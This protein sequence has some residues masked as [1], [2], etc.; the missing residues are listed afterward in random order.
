MGHLS[1]AALVR[2]KDLKS[3]GP[4]QCWTGPH[5][6]AALC[7]PPDRG[8]GAQAGQRHLR[9]GQRQHSAQHKES[10]AL[11]SWMVHEY[12]PGNEHTPASQVSKR[13]WQ[14]I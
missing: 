7:Q 9:V 1:P 8:H 6:P 5:R 14:S 10:H 13:G 3:R 4:V 2:T 12:A 11:H